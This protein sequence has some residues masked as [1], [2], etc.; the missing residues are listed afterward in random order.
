MRH[1][2]SFTYLE[3]GLDDVSLILIFSALME[4][5]H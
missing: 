5:H 1:I 2:T 4:T 3:I